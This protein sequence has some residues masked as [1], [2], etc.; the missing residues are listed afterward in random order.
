MVAPNSPIDIIVT[1]ILVEAQQASA[2]LKRFG[3]VVDETARKTQTSA[4]LIEAVSK[5][6][7]VGYGV[8]AKIVG[9]LNANLGLTEKQLNDVAVSMDKADR[10]GAFSRTLSGVNALRIALGALVSILIFQVLQAFSSMVQG[11][12][13]GLTEIE[14]AMF[15]L[16]TA[17]EKL[18]KMGVEITPQGLDELIEKLQI[19]DPMLSKFQATEL[20]ST[21]ATKVAPVARLSTEELGSL[22]EIITILAVKN[23]AL[24]K[25]FEEVQQQVI[26]GLLSGR[27]TTGINQLGAK[28]TEQAVQEEA[29]RLQLVA[30]TE[31]YKKLNAESKARVDILAITS[32]LEG[33]QAEEMSRLPEFMQTATGLIGEAQ[34]KFQNV[35]TSIGQALAP[36]LKS[37]LRI[38]IDILEKTNQWL[39][40]NKEGIGIVTNLWAEFINALG[41]IKGLGNLLGAALSLIIPP[42]TIGLR[43]ATAIVEKL[44]QLANIFPRL[45]GLFGSVATDTPTAPSDFRLAESVEQE[46]EK[47]KEATKKLQD[48]MQDNADKLADIE[49]DYQ[50]KRE[51]IARDFSEKIADIARDTARKREDAE[52]DYSQKIEDINRSANEK[53]AE[54]QADFRKK[55]E[56]REKEYQNR[57]RELREKFLFDLEDALRAR[58]ARQVLRLIRQ[59]ELDK[60]N[61]EERRKLQ[62][63]DDAANLQQ[64]LEEIE[65]ERQLKLEAA[66]REYDDK[67]EEIARGEARAL[68]EA[69]R[70][71]SRQL[72][73]ARLHYQRQLADQRAFLARKLADLQQAY[74]Q[75]L[76][77][78]NNFQS[79]LSGLQTT[80]AGT[81]IP[82]ASFTPYNAPQA[83]IGSGL[84][85][86]YD[87]RSIYQKLGIPGFA[88]GGTMVARKPT[89]AL[90]GEKTPEIASFT[91]INKVNGNGGLSGGGGM[92]GS[93]DLRI[94]ISEGL[95]ADI[96][97]AS[98][99]SVAAHVEHVRR[100]E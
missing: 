35:L 73:D 90:F 7:G 10:N 61:L 34:A 42:L 2:E 77:M 64:K 72:A 18:S 96:V 23:K 56:D 39:D 86:P 6:L 9:Q 75:E 4:A 74:A 89:L 59:F 13:K 95:I 98:L 1:R 12:L 25:S 33:Q 92:G 68:A 91:P 94:S 80:Q 37:V 55:E 78:A 48:I 57:L 60:K 76:A 24:G 67:L 51:D 41:G 47:A 62:K 88:D 58:D 17:E 14:A 43:I 40:D 32:L 70:W 15:N 65:R 30:T 49:R 26:T 100:S 50:R 5:K 87:I 38:I 46:A 19:L 11:A 31:Q 8:A 82:S 69:R 29:L 54:A 21:L 66:K 97:E 16:A 93:L 63:K 44:Q 83:G 27:V 71:Q 84:Y 36:I 3:I 28:I 99:E 22:A 53:I 85:N 52:R 20:V 45:K 79:S 81:S